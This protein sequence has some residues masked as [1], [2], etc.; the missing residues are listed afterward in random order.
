[1][2]PK[3]KAT[4]KKLS[5]DLSNGAEFLVGETK[6][7]SNR[8]LDKHICIGVTGFSG[9]GKSTFI[10]SLVH[11]L[12]YSNEAVLGG[13]LPA[14]DQKI[15]D[16]KLL[17]LD[18]I[19]LFDYEAGITALASNPPMWPKSTTKLSGCVV[20]IRYKRESIL[21]SVLSETTSLK[22]EIRDYPGEW[23]LDIP[24]LDHDYLSWCQDTAQLFKTDER[25]Q[26]IGPLLN[27]LQ[28]LTPFDRLSENEITQ[29]CQHYSDFLKASK[30]HG[31]TLIQ[32]GHMLLPAED[33]DF[34]PF[35]PLLGLNHYD[36]D[37]LEQASDNS[38][39][40]VMERRYQ[41]YLDTVVKPFHHDFF[42]GVDRQL[43]LI[44][45]LKALSGGQQN[46]DDMMIAFSR[47]IDSYKVGTR[48]IINTLL[49]P[50]VERIIFLSSKPDR[51]LMNQHENLR[52]FTDSIIKRV[53][54]QSTRNTIDIE[55]EIACSVRC[56]QD[57][58]SYLTAVLSS[59]QKGE[60][61]HPTIPETIPTTPEQWS[62]FDNWQP[63]ELQPPFIADLK[64]GAR[65]PCIRMDKVLKDLIG[66]K[67]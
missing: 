52:Q 22:V 53:C 10:T 63:P 47:I 9:S 7:L 36:R 67:F 46:F 59:G 34:L 35:V 20:E 32:P 39:Y 61:R 45:T 54:K 40:K 58:D 28:S 13:F 12:R 1:V 66:D 17:P 60:L 41:A 6:K 50:K 30:D 51:V 14:R 55:T 42:K 23:L 64:Y 48:N 5:A 43:V 8:L 65:L 3:F 29:L 4:F 33:D 2:S 26:L 27:T 44:D 49:S 31:L 19:P 15:V 38:I 24:L 37:S 18:N 21:K 16:V 11:Q 57:N 56:T 25:K 62:M